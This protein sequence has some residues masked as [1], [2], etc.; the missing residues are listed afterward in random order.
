M[1][2]IIKQIVIIALMFSATIGAEAATST[3]QF[4]FTSTG[5]EQ[6]IKYSGVSL[7]L[8]AG[9]SGVWSSASGTCGEFQ[10]SITGNQIRVTQGN[11]LSG[12]ATITFTHSSKNI[13]YAKVVKMLNT[14]SEVEV[15][16]EYDNSN[17]A[18][19]SIRISGTRIKTIEL[20]LSDSDPQYDLAFADL[21]NINSSYLYTG[22]AITPE[23]EV[24]K[25]NTKLT[26]GT[27]YTV[28]YTNNI[29]VGTATVTVTGT[30]SYTGSISQKFTIST[31]VPTVTP[32]TILGPFTYDGTAHTLC[33][34]GTTSV[35]TLEYSTDNSTW[36]TSLPTA[37]N[38][39]TYRIYYRV[40]ATTN[41]AEVTS[42]WAGTATINPA[43]THNGCLTFDR[44]ATDN[45]SLTI[46]ESDGS[47]EQD[48]SITDDVDN[49]KSITMNR[50]FTVDKAATV[51][52]PFSIATSKIIGGTFYS[53]I[54]VD[55]TNDGW[56]VVMKEVNRQS[57]TLQAHTPYLFM[58]SATEMT[59]D[60]DG[61]SVTVKA[62]SQQTYTIQP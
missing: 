36:I 55:K 51:M 6:K 47:A 41:N 56:D 24:W 33:S 31:G 8:Y 53:F 13:V 15:T 37:T 26:K 29:N 40:P 27:H 22:S 32:P 25:G 42:S 14:T 2:H 54:G 43:T 1:K 44:Y 9:S 4:S 39:G 17:S 49:V 62:N 45:V 57:G 20:K 18:Q 3:V 7:R 19:K 10:V 21:F 34:A 11:Y 28:S 46:G 16:S 5:G 59:F 48:I 50:T 23:P 30:G 60:L 61:E 12:N 38:G 52:L 35:G 58:P